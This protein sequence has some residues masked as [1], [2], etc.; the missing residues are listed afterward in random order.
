VLDAAVS[1][2]NLVGAQA[3]QATAHSEGLYR[4]LPRDASRSL[5]FHKLNWNPDHHSGHNYG[6]PMPLG[7]DPL[8]IGQLEFI[9]RWIEAGAPFEGFVVDSTLLQDSRKQYV[10]P[11]APLAPPMQGFQ[12]HIDSFP[13][14]PNFE[15]ELFIYRRVGNTATAYVNRIETRMRVNSHHFLALTFADTT[16]ANVIPQFDVIRD[17]RAPDGS[18]IVANMTMMGWQNFYAGANSQYEDKVFPPGVALELPANAALDLNS[19]YIN[20]TTQSI[21]GEVYINF[22]TLPLS[23]VQK[24]ARPFSFT[25]FG[26]TLP[27]NTRTTVTYTA[28]FDRTTT[29]MMLTSHN[30]GMGEKFVIKIAGGPRDGEVVYTSTD[31]AHPVILWLTQPL[32]LQPGEG[33][34]SVV[35]YNNTTSRTLYHGLLS[36]DEMDVMRGYAY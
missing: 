2:T 13:I 15:R 22:Y 10:Q 8:T 25:N 23:Q 35:T 19:H 6:N 9:R 18:M 14:A 20:T 27:P 24:I 5:L 34:T 7:S 31:W 32:V 11:F 33:L 1:Y 16:P 28:T 29:I 17:I 12:L 21:P 36:T 3:H 26:L 30:H 4:V